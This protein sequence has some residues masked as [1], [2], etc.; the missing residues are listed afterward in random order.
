MDL[1]QEE[2]RAQY[3]TL[4]TAEVPVWESSSAHLGRHVASGVELPDAIDWT[5]KG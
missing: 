4:Q 3:L 2:F 1:T 5:T